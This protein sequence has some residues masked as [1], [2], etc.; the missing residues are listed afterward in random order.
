MGLGVP[1]PQLLQRKEGLG[2]IHHLY[3]ED[4]PPTLGRIQPTSHGPQANGSKAED[5]RRRQYPGGGEGRGCG[6]GLAL[7]GKLVHYLGTGP[8][9]RWG[10]LKGW[11]HH[12]ETRSA[13]QLLGR[14]KGLG[15]SPADRSLSY[16]H[17]VKSWSAPRRSPIFQPPP[18]GPESLQGPFSHHRCLKHLPASCLSLRGSDCQRPAL[19]QH[20]LSSGASGLSAPWIR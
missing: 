20:G 3:A 8:H 12:L 11:R 18:S 16:K 19:P 4:V 7:T 17:S 10:P 15:G 14:R 2:T 5:P 13:A 1:P 9:S 6:S